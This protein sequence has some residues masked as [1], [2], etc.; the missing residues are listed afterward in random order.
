MRIDVAFQP[1]FNA[2]HERMMSCLW[3]HTHMQ[4]LL[5]R[6][7]TDPPG[8][9][10]F[11]PNKKTFFGRPTSLF[12]F[13]FSFRFLPPPPQRASER[14]IKAKRRKGSPTKFRSMPDL[15]AAEHAALAAT[16]D[17]ETDIEQEV[18]DFAARLA[19][20]VVTRAFREGSAS[21]AAAAATAEEAGYSRQRGAGVRGDDGGSNTNLDPDPAGLSS[22]RGGVGRSALSLYTAEAELSLRGW[23]RLG[24][25]LEEDAGALR[26]RVF[27]ALLENA[28]RLHA[29][30][31][32]ID[33]VGEEVMPEVDATVK[34]MEK[35]VYDLEELR[36]EQV[37][38]RAPHGSFGLGVALGAGLWFPQTREDDGVAVPEVFDTDAIFRVNEGGLAPL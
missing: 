32:A 21:G 11:S 30:Y 16:D 12:R 35:A 23:Q 15:S 26:L 14:S 13:D 29:L 38:T 33:R 3:F 27:P 4:L 8:R 2:A 6:T 19:R 10:R 37:D 24:A 9:F 18:K 28:R 17:P 20:L 7:P 34:R 1:R 31:V 22:S 25:Q 36:K 5:Y